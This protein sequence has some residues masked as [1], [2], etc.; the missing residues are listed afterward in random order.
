M[1]RP[2]SLDLRERVVAAVASGG[3]CRE[4]AETFDIAPST[5]VKWS[6]RQRETGHA[7]AKPMGGRRRCPIEAERDFLLARVQEKPDITLRELASELAERGLAVSHVSVWNL[8]RREEQTFKKNRSRQ[9]AG[10]S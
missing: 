6:E 7:A 4:V 2:Y 5:V 3:T 9:R 10:S 8:L 1:A